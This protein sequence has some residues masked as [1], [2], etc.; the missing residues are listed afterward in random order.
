MNMY[1]FLLIRDVTI[2]S[3]SLSFSLSHVVV[4]APLLNRGF[5]V[6]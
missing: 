5:F 6:I 4:V 1:I 3:I 2:L